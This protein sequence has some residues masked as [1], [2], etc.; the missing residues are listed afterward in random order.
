MRRVRAA[1]AGANG[2]AGMTLVNLLELHPGVELAQLTS[3]SFAGRPY[4]S[5]FPLLERKGEFLAAPEPEQ[6]DVIFSCLPHNVGAGLAAEW[7]TRGVRVID[8]SAD[9]RLKDAN[10]Y[11]RWYGQDHPSPGVLAQAVFGLPELHAAELPQA[12]LIAVPGCYSTASILALA[13]A[14]KAGLAG[15][16]VVVDAKSG[17][18]GAGRSVGLGTH[19]SEVSDSVHAYAVSG[20]RHL[21]ELTQELCSLAPAKPPQLTFVPHLI[22][23]VRG[24]LTTC[25]FDLMSPRDELEK[26]YFDFY[27]GQPFTQVLREPAATKLAAHTNRC[28]INVSQQGP[29][30]V[31]TAAI[32]NLLKGAAGQAVECFNLAFAFERGEGLR[33]AA[34]WP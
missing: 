23:M 25:Y 11:P 27:A 9:F 8:L 14:V 22:P 32:D 19:F 16:D 2:Y 5:V 29:K 33:L 24:I 6:V 7:L 28:L 26:V 12:R 15:P 21:A 30:A 31:V 18:S 34:Q 17:V 13:P 4:Q 3:R 10:Q 20:H 1:V